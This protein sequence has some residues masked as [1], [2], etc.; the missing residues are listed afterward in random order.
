MLASALTFAIAWYIKD[1]SNAY[2]LGWLSSTLVVFVP[3]CVPILQS[4]SVSANR[5]ADELFWIMIPL[6]GGW[7]VGVAIAI[8][9]ARIVRWKE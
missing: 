7:L 1:R 5:A 6:L 3:S 8:E 9:V 4:D 2:R